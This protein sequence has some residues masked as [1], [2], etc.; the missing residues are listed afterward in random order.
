MDDFLWHLCLVGLLGNLCLQGAVR[1]PIA[2]KPCYPEFHDML[3]LRLSLKHFC[4][5]F[6]N[7]NLIFTDFDI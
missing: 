1:S 7:N 3:I 6:L 2:L 5:M 4:Y